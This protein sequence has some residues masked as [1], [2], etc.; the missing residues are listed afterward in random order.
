MTDTEMEQAM[1]EKPFKEPKAKDEQPKAKPE[2]ANA[3]PATPTPAENL[4][5]DLSAHLETLGTQDEI[6]VWWEAVVQSTADHLN[7]K[8]FSQLVSKKQAQIE[9]V[10]KGKK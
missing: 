2:E 10:A 4:L 6:K 1:E 7:Q 5:A 9:K 8:Q 3:E